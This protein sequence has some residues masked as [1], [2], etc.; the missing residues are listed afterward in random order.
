MSGWIFLSG[1]EKV[2]GEWSSWGDSSI[3]SN[4]NLEVERRTVYRLY[5]KLCPKCGAHN[6]F[7]N[8]PCRD[9]SYKLPTTSSTT[10]WVDTPYSQL[11]AKQYSN[12]SKKMVVG[13]NSKNQWFFNKADLNK[14]NPSDSD[15][16]KY[17]Y[18]SRTITYIYTFYRWSDW[19]QWSDTV[20]SSSSTRDV[21]TRVMYRYKK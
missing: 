11:G 16:I 21:E 14:T 19:S 13:S 2:Y 18:R 15:F 20:V 10:K 4:N 9:C 1:P 7:D 17:Q 3:S 5:Y 12:S 6:A 8:D